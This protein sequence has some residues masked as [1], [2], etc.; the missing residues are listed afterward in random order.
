MKTEIKALV[1]EM[2]AFVTHQS[3]KFPKDAGWSSQVQVFEDEV[4][5]DMIYPRVSISLA[6]SYP[7]WFLDNDGQVIRRAQ[8][9]DLMRAFRN[10]VYRPS[11]DFLALDTWLNRAFEES[12]ERS[13]TA[14]RPRVKSVAKA[15][16][17]PKKE[18]PHLRLSRATRDPNP[19]TPSDEARAVRGSEGEK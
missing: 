8:H 1:D 17:A 7:I 12:A 5:F 4:I 2:H 6:C 18:Y 11:A 14:L 19:D 15:A 3:C 10:G 9:S 13:I 16:L